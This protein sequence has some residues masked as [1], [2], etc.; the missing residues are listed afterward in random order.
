MS[1][2]DFKNLIEVIDI[3]ADIQTNP[4]IF[5]H[6]PCEKRGRSIFHIADSVQMSAANQRVV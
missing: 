4:F 5:L 2:V 1:D 3:Y 6:F